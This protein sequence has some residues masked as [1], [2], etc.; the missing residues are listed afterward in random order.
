MARKTM[1]A[2]ATATK[3]NTLTL[4]RDKNKSDERAMAEAAIGSSFASAFTAR[5]FARG[6]FGELDLTESVA[7]M[8]EQAKKVRSGDLSEGEGVL[9]AQAL[10]LD[11]IFNE[12]ARR[13][14]L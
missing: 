11:A 3:A 10:A 2:A 1:K 9:M 8:A 4:K 13:A 14:A 6:T 7:V 12:L 5:A